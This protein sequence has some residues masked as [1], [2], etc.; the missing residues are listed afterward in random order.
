MLKLTFLAE[1]EFACLY[2]L[3]RPK[4]AREAARTA[5]TAAQS[6]KRPDLVYRAL[7]LLSTI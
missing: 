5:L 6:M 1:L 7:D 2:S 4:L 3:R